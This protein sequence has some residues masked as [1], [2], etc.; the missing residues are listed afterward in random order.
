MLIQEAVWILSKNNIM[1][2]PVLNPDPNVKN[3]CWQGR[4][5]GILDYPAI[6]GCKYN[7]SDV[8]ASRYGSD[9]GFKTPIKMNFILFPR[10]RYFNG[11][12]IKGKIKG[13]K[14]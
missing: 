7:F 4:F 14:S 10:F 1:S 6:V 9:S 3:R 2:V 13:M 12:S 5:L 8:C 11:K